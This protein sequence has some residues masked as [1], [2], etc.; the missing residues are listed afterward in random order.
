MWESEFD[1]IVSKKVKLQDLSFNQLKLKVYD[2][3]KKYEIITTSFEPSD[4]S[5]AKNKAYLDK[6]SSKIEGQISYIEKDYNEF[7]FNIDKLSVEE[8]LIDRAVKTTIQLLY[9]KG[10]FDK[11]DNADEVL[12]FFLKNAVLI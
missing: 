1:N 10:A 6:K 5:D 9:D 7:K 2:A 11:Y 4:D 3:Y 12:N 8:V